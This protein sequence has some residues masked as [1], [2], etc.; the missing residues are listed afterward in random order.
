MSFE[1][2]GDEDVSGVATTHYTL[3]EADRE[4]VTQLYDID[5][6]DWAGDVWIAKDGGYAMQ[7]AWGP[8]SIE[9]AQISTGFSYLV[10]AVNCECPIEPPA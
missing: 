1:S 10:T 6:A 3:S 4:D 2:V 8:Q 9:D 7:L 5:P